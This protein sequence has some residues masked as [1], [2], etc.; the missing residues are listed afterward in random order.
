MRIRFEDADLERIAADAAFTGGLDA[1]RV[2]GFPKV[3]AR[4]VD[5]LNEHSLR[6]FR[7]LNF[8]ALRGDRAGEY[9]LRINDQWRLIVTIEAGEGSN[10]NVIVVRAIEDYH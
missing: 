7:G 10:N 2:K 4:L 3:V 1:A 8:E 9:S 5:A 6:Q